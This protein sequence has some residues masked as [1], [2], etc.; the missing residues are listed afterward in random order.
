M[1]SLGRGGGSF[2]GVPWLV[3][4]GHKQLGSR[5]LVTSWP[6]GAGEQ[7]VKDQSVGF[8]E[9]AHVAR[10]DKTSPKFKNSTPHLFQGLTPP[11]PNTPN[12]TF[13]FLQ[14][15]IPSLLKHTG[16]ELRIAIYYS[17]V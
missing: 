16:A 13:V 7:L 1:H 9:A 8:M 3:C 14:S 15:F 6:P 11:T 10:Q 5:Y 17:V 4:L 2:N 12:V